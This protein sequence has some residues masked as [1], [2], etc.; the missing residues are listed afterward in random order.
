MSIDNIKTSLEKLRSTLESSG[1]VDSELKGLLQSL[2]AD[3]QELLK[4]TEAA[5]STTASAPAS[6]LR[7][8]LIERAQGISARLAVRHP[9]LQPVLR[10][11]A[12]TLTNMGI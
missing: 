9:H 2:D 3:I 12:D 7:S 6:D 8:A 4:S 11:I 5:T 1:T 10:E